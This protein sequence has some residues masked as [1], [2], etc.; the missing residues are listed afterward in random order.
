MNDL[1]R[2]LIKQR[3]ASQITICTK[4]QHRNVT[5]VLKQ[6]ETLGDFVNSA[7]WWIDSPQGCEYWNRIYLNRD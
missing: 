7:M 5:G 4:K 2:L 3:W 1:T 6:K